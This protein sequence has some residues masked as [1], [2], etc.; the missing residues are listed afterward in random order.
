MSSAEIE[1]KLASLPELMKSKGFVFSKIF[2]FGS[3][4]KNK[5]TKYSDIDLAI[6]FN[7]LKDFKNLDKVD[8]SLKLNELLSEVDDRI[9]PHFLLEKEFIDGEES[10]LAYEIKNHGVLIEGSDS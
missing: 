8:N 10:I 3:V 1:K 4:A 6:V 9:E 7:S 5:A 2:L